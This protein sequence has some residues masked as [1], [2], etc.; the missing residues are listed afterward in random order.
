MEDTNN[1]ATEFPHT[2]EENRRIWDVNALWWDDRVGDGNGF[3]DLLIEPATERLLE[4]GPGDVVLDIACG[5]GRMARRIASA[6]ARVVAFDQSRRFIERAQ[7][8][9]GPEVVVEYHVANAADP[10]WFASLGHDSFDKAV[11]TMALMDMPEIR[12]LA[13]L[14]PRVLKRAGVF[15]FS[16]THPCFHTPRTQRFAEVHDDDAGR[17]EIHNGVKV[18]SYLTPFAAKTQGIIGQPEP[19]YYFHRP[20]QTLLRPFL[21]SG[22]MLDGIEEPCLPVPEE[23]KASTRWSDMPDVAPILVVRLR[24]LRDS[25]PAVHEE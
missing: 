9:T 19:Q 3:Q 25:A 22:F 10:V 23:K 20:L 4:I 8:R 21:E 11:C 18:F 16:L 5:A 13:T 14:L 17:T 15:V 7:S 24:L 6:G 2:A 1:S 12:P